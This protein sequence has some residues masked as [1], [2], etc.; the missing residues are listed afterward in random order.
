MSRRALDRYLTP[1]WATKA[2]LAEFPE[3]GGELLLDPCSGDGRMAKILCAGGRFTS[4]ALND[5]DEDAPAHLHLDAAD[6][7]LYAECPTWT[8]SNPP[9]NAAGDIVKIAVDESKNI[10]MLLRCTFG[11]PCAASKRFPRAGRQWLKT[12]PPTAILMLPRISFTGDGN[13]DTAPCWWFIWS[14]FVKPRIACR[15]RAESAG[16]LSL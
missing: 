4:C 11:E 12:L 6:P 10:A 7:V 1:D 5:L 9:F 8:I 2:L 13:S 15:G 16:Q 3:I 14:H